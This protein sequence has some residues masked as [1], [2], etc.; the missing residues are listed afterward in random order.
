MSGAA[1]DRGPGELESRAVLDVRV[2]ATSYAHATRCV[3]GWARGG[4]SRYVCACN[5]HMVMEARDDPSF[6]DVVNGA[7][8]VTPDGMPLVWALRLMGV[9][10]AT[11]VYGPTLMLEVSAAAERSAVPIGL[12]GGSQSVLTR[13][14]ERLR[15]RFPDLNVAYAHSPP[16][17]PH[18]DERADLE[19]IARSGVRILFVALGCPKQ[20][21]W[22]ARNRDH[23]PAV[24]LGVGA[25]F[26][27]VAGSKPQAPGVLQ[28]TGLEWAFRL[29]TEP[30]RLWRRYA[31]HNPRFVALLTRQLLRR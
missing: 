17:G 10:S 13:V 12:Y 7:D 31:V 18:D 27:F 25:A 26:D 23:V 3:I 11:R 24:T 22:M 21:R 15:E 4:A 9:R 20:E 14:R 30:R 16:F 5:V 1:L 29:A 2:D 28:R 8:L 6:R 19:A